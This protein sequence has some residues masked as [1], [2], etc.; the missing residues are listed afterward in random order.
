MI[1]IAITATASAN[2]IGRPQ[3]RDADLA[4]PENHVVLYMHALLLDLSEHT[5]PEEL[6]RH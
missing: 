6:G 1:Q 5:S 2:V 3:K 4:K